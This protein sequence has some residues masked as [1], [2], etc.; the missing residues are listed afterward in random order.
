MQPPAGPPVCTAL[1][2]RPSTMPPPMSNT[3]SRRVVPIGTSTSPVFT[4]RP[5]RAKTLVPLLVAVPIAANQSPP[6]RMMGAMLANVSTLLMSVGRPQSPD[7]AGYGGRGLG[8]PRPPSMDAMSAVSSPHTN[9]PAPSRTSTSNAN[10]RV[11]HGRAEVAAPPGLVDRLAEA[12]DRERVLGSAVDVARL[13]ADRVRGDRHPLQHPEWIA[14]EDAPVHER[15]G[16]PLVRVADDV[17]V[18]ARCLGDRVPFQA[19]RVSRA[20]AAAQAAPGDLVAHLGGCHRREAQCGEQRS[21]RPPGSRRGS[22]DRSRPEFSVAIRTCRAKNAGSG[23]RSAPGTTAAIAAMIGSSASGPT[24][25]KSSPVSWIWTSGPAAHRPR[26]PT[27]FTATSVRLALVTWEV[28]PVRMSSPEADMQL[29]ASQTYADARAG[30]AG[31]TPSSRWRA[32]GS[33]RAATGRVGS[34]ISVTAFRAA[35]RARR[36]APAPRPGHR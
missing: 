30:P 32:G 12:G 21:H 28:R 23:T 16:V 4:T 26:Q 5:A 19:R 10:S 36:A 27:R 29:T 3:I 14:F 22:R 15:A 33:G 17:L 8:V 6:L 2:A 7:T 18:R 31:V 25:L 11:Q 9:A 34:D 13:G 24:W 35:R 1:N 20:A